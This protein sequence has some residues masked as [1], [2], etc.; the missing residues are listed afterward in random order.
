MAQRPPNSHMIAHD[1]VSYAGLNSLP[2]K[3]PAHTVSN[4]YFAENCEVSDNFVPDRYVNTEPAYEKWLR[5]CDFYPMRR[6]QTGC[7]CYNDYYSS[8]AVMRGCLADC[9]T[10]VTLM[11]EAGQRAQHVSSL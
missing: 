8:V 5:A 3:Y 6:G 7:F 11:S 2:R 4:V 9:K 1:A 10:A